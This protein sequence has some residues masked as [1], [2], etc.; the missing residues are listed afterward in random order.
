M[1]ALWKLPV[2][3][4]IENNRYAMGTSQRALDSLTDYAAPAASPSVSPVSAVDGMDVEAMAV[5][6][7]GEKAVAH[8]RAGKGPY[9]SGER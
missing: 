3:F 5:T 9:M 2:V 8:C 4:V 1:A 7:A 6:E